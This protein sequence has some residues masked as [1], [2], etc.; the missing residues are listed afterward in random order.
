MSDQFWVSLFVAL[1]VTI[2]AMGSFVIGLIQLSRLGK[3]HKQINSRMDELLETTA[4]AA[5]AEGVKQE[6]D[7]SR[8]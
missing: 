5:K 2:A 3:V 7:R 1:P 6:L 4:K 8:I